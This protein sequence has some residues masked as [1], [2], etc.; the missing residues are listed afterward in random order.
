[1]KEAFGTSPKATDEKANMKSIIVGVWPTICDETKQAWPT[2]GDSNI[3][4]ED[5][6]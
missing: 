6:E 2:V 1:M 5:N 3:C 4:W